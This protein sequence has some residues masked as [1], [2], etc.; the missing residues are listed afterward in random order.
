MTARTETRGQSYY[1]R[2]QARARAGF[3]G[4]M[5]KG[6]IGPGAWVGPRA[7]RIG[8]G[9]AHTSLGSGGHLGQPTGSKPK[10][11]PYF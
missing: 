11:H 5:A 9:P 4:Y 7:P 8:R 10:L 3:L 2:R 1:S 6:R